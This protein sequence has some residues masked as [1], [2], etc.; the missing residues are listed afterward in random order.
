MREMQEDWR[1]RERKL[2]Q[3]PQRRLQALLS[4]YSVEG[5][6]I[7]ERVVPST[8]G[9]VQRGG[10][11]LQDMTDGAKATRPLLLRQLAEDEIPAFCKTRIE[12]CRSAEALE[13]DDKIAAD[14]VRTLEV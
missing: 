10:W 4:G 3:Q 12:L 7:G 11:G 5:H 9:M 8:A 2:R 14:D 13:G 1:L 6:K